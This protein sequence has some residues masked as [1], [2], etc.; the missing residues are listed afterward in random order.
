SF[1]DK[2][3]GKENSQL[4]TK[5]KELSE[6]LNWQAQTKGKLVNLQERSKSAVQ[7]LSFSKIETNLTMEMRMRHPISVDMSLS[8]VS[9][10]L[11]KHSK[12]AK[13]RLN[14][15]KSKV[16]AIKPVL[17]KHLSSELS[18]KG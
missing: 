5:S 6:H 9:N 1:V 14:Y 11:Q 7:E 18:K 17:S 10:P 15:A 3:F 13:G 8:E 4:L 12:W 2:A 16:N